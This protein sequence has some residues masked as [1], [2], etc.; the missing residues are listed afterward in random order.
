[1]PLPPS[2]AAA[3]AALELTVEED[4]PLARKTWWGTGGR[5][6]GYLDVV[7]MDQL[8]NAIAAAYDTDCP[9]FMLGNASNLLVSDR[10][11]RALVLR[12]AGGLAGV[13]VQGSHPPTL[14]LG[15]GV[16]LIA[17]VSRMQREGWTGLEFLAG[18]PGTVGG[19]VCMNAGTHLGDMTGALVDVGLVLRNGRPL[20]LTREQ[21]RMRYRESALPEG[22]A[23]AWARM[24][25]TGEDPGESRARIEAHMTRRA[26][27]QPV[28]VR[29][30]GSTFRNPPGDAAGRLIEAAGLKGMQVGGAVVSTKHANFIVNESNATADDIRRLI[31]LVHDKVREEAGV[32]L[33]PEV[34]LA[35]DWSHW[36]GG[37][38]IFGR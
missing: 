27:T 4:A 13:E 26:D 28:D 3:L 34:H 35:G 6:D 8:A 33:I 11:V 9:V 31:E 24:R 18:I 17:L 21:L 36:E 30:C 25:T 15:G 12:L 23:V 14:K 29:T 19:A 10:G 7:T 32:A 38:T 37:V 5:A 16:K 2:T 22:A 1:M 20:V